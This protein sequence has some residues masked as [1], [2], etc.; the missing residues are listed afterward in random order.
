MKRTLIITGII[1]FIAIIALIVFNKV[2]SK[3]DT[4]KLFTEV[5]KGRFEI[6]V[7]TTGELIA[8]K[9]VDIKGPEFA[10]RG[11]IRAMDIKILDLVPEGTIVKQGDYIAK[12]DRTNLENNLKDNLERLTTLQTNLEMKI[13]DT[14]VV[15]N[16]LRDGIRNQTYI[17]DEASITLRNSKYEPPTTIRQAEIDYDK[18]KRVLEQKERSYTLRLAQNLTDINNIKYYVSRWTRRV[19]ELQEVLSKFTITAPSPGMIIYKRDRRGNKRKTGSQINPFDRVVATL[20]DLSSMISKIYVNEIDVSKVKVGQKAS[21]TIDAFPEKS[22]TG[23]V[24][25]IANIGDNLPN[26]D[27]KVFEAQIKIDG[28]NPAFRPTMTT[29][30]KVIIKTIDDGVYIPFECV[31]TG[32]DSIPYVYTKDGTKQIVILGESNDKNII[33]EQGLEPGKSVYLNLP[34][35]PEKFRLAGDDLITII[36]EREKVRKAEYEKNRIETERLTETE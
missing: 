34:E 31:Q 32:T 13:L 24:I 11:D 35:K 4:S 3:N 2:T 25:S 21:I 28:S 26:T 18:A 36:R 22:Y 6:T 30:N 14:A 16:D 33:I 15:L 9:S 1:V 7:T 19:N 23:T 8:E 29:G 27:S 17:V 12:L 20:P 5:K 10:I